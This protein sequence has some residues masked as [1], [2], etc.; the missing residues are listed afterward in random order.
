MVCTA[1][2]RAFDVQDDRM[3]VG[4][5]HSELYQVN[6]WLSPAAQTTCLFSGHWDGELW[7]IDA[8]PR[9]NGFATVGED[10]KIILWD[11]REHKMLTSQ[12]ITDKPGKARKRERYVITCFCHF[13]IDRSIDRG[14]TRAVLCVVLWQCFDDVFVPRERVRARHPLQPRRLARGHRHKRRRTGGVRN[15]TTHVH[16]L[17]RPQQIRKTKHHQKVGQ[18]DPNHQVSATAALG[19]V[20]L[21]SA[22]LC[23]A[24]CL[25]VCLS[26]CLFI[27]FCVV[28]CCCCFACH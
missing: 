9:G 24:L 26:V 4:T 23:S 28:L 22:R 13:M 21:G 14:L 12:R 2:I 1:A 6:N 11:H 10:N 19:C 18:L 3:V 17:P 25:F 20:W 15:Q 5:E 16:R 7:A 27:P 8:E